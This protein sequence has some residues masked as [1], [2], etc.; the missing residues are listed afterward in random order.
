VNPQAA[1]ARPGFEQRH[2]MASAFR[3][4]AGQ[5]AAGGAG[6]HHDEIECVVR[7]SRA[8]SGRRSI[9]T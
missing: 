3:K 1:V 7:H 6:A 2:A 8:Y 5:D 4:P 9:G